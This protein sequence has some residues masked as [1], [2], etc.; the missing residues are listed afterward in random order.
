MTKAVFAGFKLM[1]ER[2]ALI[3][4]EA[5]SSPTAFV[6]RHLFEVLQDA[7][8]QMVNLTKSILLQIAARFLAADTA[9]AEHGD[10]LA[11]LP[12]QK[13]PQRVFGPFREL[14]EAFRAWIEGT[15]EAADRCFVAVAGVDDQG[16]G[17]I[18]QFIPVLGVHIRAHADVWIHVAQAD[19]HNLKSRVSV[20]QSS[21]KEDRVPC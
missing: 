6:F 19:G 7:S 14:P 18:H 12:F 10:P 17:V 15:F 21:G 8:A 2:H 13:R 1:V 20:R 16:V 9:G 11:T 4:D 5:L 3:E